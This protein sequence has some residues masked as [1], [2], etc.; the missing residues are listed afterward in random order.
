MGLAARKLAVRALKPLSA[1]RYGGGDDEEQ[2]GLQPGRVRGPRQCQTAEQPQ[3]RREDAWPGASSA[4]PTTTAGT[5]IRKDACASN[6]SGSCSR[7]RAARPATSSEAPAAIHGECG[8]IR[9]DGEVI[10]DRKT[11]IDPSLPFP[12]TAPRLR[13]SP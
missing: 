7:T 9:A 8:R 11:R 1:Q 13:N 2:Q 4:A 12:A 5:K 6:G 10:G 3:Q